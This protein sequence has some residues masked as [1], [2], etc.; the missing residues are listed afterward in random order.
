ME[1]YEESRK[2][3]EGEPFFCDV[4]CRWKPEM[5]CEVPA[6]YWQEHKEFTWAL[7]S[8]L[9]PR[10]HAGWRRLAQIRSE[11]RLRFADMLVIAHLRF[12]LPTMSIT[13]PLH[14]L[15]F[16]LNLYVSTSL[17]AKMFQDVVSLISV[18]HGM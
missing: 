9:I 4:A 10:P 17:L 6:I 16:I 5:T 1:I 15:L 12:V 2:I 7:E 13:R 11:G 8:H 18:I 14:S 3:L